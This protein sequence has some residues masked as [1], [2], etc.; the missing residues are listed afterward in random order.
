MRVL[1]LSKACLVGI[2]Q[3]KLEE[4]AAASPDLSLVVAVP[5]FWKDER[6]I[7]SLERAYVHGYK[8][9]VTPMALNGQFHL[10]FYPEFKKLL[11]EFK[12]DI[13]HID[14]EPYNLATFQA[15]YQA[16]Y[17]GART[18]WFSWQNL[19]R[20]YPPPFSWLEG[21]NLK[22]T[23]YAIVG[24]QTAKQIWRA[25]GYTG[26]LAVIPQFGVDPDIF[27]LAS[28]PST[29][30][31]HIGYVGRLVEEK[32]VDLLLDALS[33]LSRK[34]WQ[35]SILGSGPQEVALQNQAKVLGLGQNVSFRPSIPSMY[36]PDFYQDLDILVL[37]SR[38]RPNWM[39]Q[40]G[41]VLV[42]AMACGVVVVGAE[43]GE[44]PYVIGDAGVTFPEDDIGALRSVL[45]QLSVS[46]AL[47]QT[48]SFKGRQRVLNQ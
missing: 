15:N 29:R 23:D 9:V 5:P 39:E 12:P 4:M 3:R 24:S 20:R 18:L 27:T 37:P 10:H 16:R 31:L 22:H 30:K 8:L 7:T 36:M 33:G 43:S 28:S 40:F 17:A 44:I 46:S 32:G 13:V 45:E 14:E 47:R 1:M 35:L 38:T 25:K 21:Y 42:E 41:R 26:P 6:G 2:Y 19:D 48:L 34:D 11:Q